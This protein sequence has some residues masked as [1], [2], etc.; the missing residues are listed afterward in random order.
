MLPK[1][2]AVPTTTDTFD[3]GLDWASKTYKMRLQT[4]HVV[5]YTDELDAMEQ[6]VYKI[7]QTERYQHVMYSWNY[8]VELEDLIG[9]PVSQAEPEIQR[10]ITEAL[11]QDERVKSVDGFSFER[12]QGKVRVTFTVHTVFG[13]LQGEKELRL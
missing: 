5:G 3:D 6:A 10:R 13:E 1:F 12:K 8:G 11:T 2:N 9:M 4:N 7:L